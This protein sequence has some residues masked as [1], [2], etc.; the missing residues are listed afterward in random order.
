MFQRGFVSF[1][2]DYYVSFIGT[3]ILH[4]V[5]IYDTKML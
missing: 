2:S 4:S 3:F 5:S 1:I